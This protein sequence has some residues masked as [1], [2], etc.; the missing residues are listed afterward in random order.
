MSKIN[1]FKPNSP[2]QPGMFTGRLDEIRRT[3]ACLVQT[4]SGSAS[5]FMLTGERGIGKSSLM[6][7]VSWVAEGGIPLMSSA[8]V[9][10]LVID[11]DVDRNTTQLGLIQK[12]EL[13]LGRKLAQTEPARE[14][15]KQVWGFLQRVEAGGVRLKPSEK[16]DSDERLVEEFAYSIATIVERTCSS[17]NEDDLFGEKYDGVLLLV[18]EADNASKELDLG[19]FLKLLMERLQRKACERFMVG[20][21]GLP[22]LRSVLAESHP[23]SLRLFDEIKLDRLAEADVNSVIDRALE[24]GLELNGKATTIE[25]PARKALVNLSEGFPHFIQQF[26]YSAFAKD[27]DDNISVEDVMAGAF[28][29]GGALEAIGDRYYRDDFYDKVQKDS[30]RQVLRIMADELD[31]WVTK[32]DIKKKFKG[33]DSTLDNAI[34]ALRDRKVI[35]SKEGEAGVYRLRHRGFALWIKLY[36]SAPKDLGTVVNTGLV[37]KS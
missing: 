12:I 15:W 16:Q 10:F 20:L 19:S 33:P 22:S 31:G 18:D 8:T 5:G 7:L 1:P 9:K 30:Y 14:L 11:T 26:G 29:K 6:T 2:V 27:A 23:S 13:G 37:A 35:L 3:E 25:P 21:A 17:A 36:T 34:K 32:K 24:R 28:G 4:K